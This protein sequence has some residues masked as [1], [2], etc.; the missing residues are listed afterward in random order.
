MIDQVPRSPLMWQWAGE[1]EPEAQLWLWPSVDGSHSS[2]QAQDFSMLIRCPLPAK[3]AS[4]NLLA[5]LTCMHQNTLLKANLFIWT[6]DILYLNLCYK[7]P[8]SP[9]SFK[10]TVL[11]PLWWPL[12]LRELGYHV[13]IRYGVDW[14]TPYLCM[15]LL[16]S[17]TREMTERV[18][19]GMTC[20][21]DATSKARLN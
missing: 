8:K 21:R 2:A 13:C 18:R 16:D 11:F 14:S 5:V 6:V 3:Q 10:A 12:L 1:P 17:N 15:S 4:W 9:L 19:W 20:N 7:L